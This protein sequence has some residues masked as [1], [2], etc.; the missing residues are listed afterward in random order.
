MDSPPEELTNRSWLH[1]R[2]VPIS[3]ALDSLL[4]WMEHEWEDAPR[5]ATAD[6]GSHDHD[7]HLPL[8][9]GILEVDRA[10]G[11]G[12]RQGHLTV[13]EAEL[14]SQSDAVLWS[15]ARNIRHKTVLDVDQLLGAVAWIWAGGSGVPTIAMTQGR[16]TQKEWQRAIDS[17]SRLTERPLYLGQAESVAGLAALAASR[18]ARVL[19]VQDLERFGDP[20]GVYG[21]LARLAARTGLAVLG[22]ARTT[23]AVPEGCG[24]ITTVVQVLRSSMGGTAR[25]V[26]ADRIEMLSV[27]EVRMDLVTGRVT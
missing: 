17:I 21:E 9:T 19:M 27:H 16:M 24:H 15:I 6:A 10:L 25:F 20:P 18:R 8:D 1:D 4:S 26:L 14:P 13:L 22:T 3:D 2:A 12:L 5:S 23:G 11:G 7:I